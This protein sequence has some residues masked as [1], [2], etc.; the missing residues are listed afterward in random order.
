MAETTLAKQRTRQWRIKIEPR[1]D[2]PP[3]WFPAAVSLGAVLVALILG[4]HTDFVRR[5]KP[6]RLLRPHCTRLLW[7]D[8]RV[9]RHHRESHPDH[10][11]SPCLLD[12]IPDEVVEHRRGRTIHHGRLGCERDRADPGAGG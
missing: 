10:P 5:R 8:W 11:D 6:V 12:C 3:A 9:I 1:L 4:G 7:R 2:E